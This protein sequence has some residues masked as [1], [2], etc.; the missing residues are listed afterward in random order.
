MKGQLPP[1]AVIDLG[2]R[3]RQTCIT[4]HHDDYMLLEVELARIQV[5]LGTEDFKLRGR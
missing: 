1:P 3:Q 2:G 5:E 4:H